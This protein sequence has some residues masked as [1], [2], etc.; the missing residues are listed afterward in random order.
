M[1]ISAVE[2][3]TIHS[4]NNEWLYNAVYS[5]VL[6]YTTELLESISK[7]DKFKRYNITTTDYLKIMDKLTKKFRYN[8]KGV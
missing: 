4:E 7:K 8:N 1:K 2:I 3:V 6:Y 5:E